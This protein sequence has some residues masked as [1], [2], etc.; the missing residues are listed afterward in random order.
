MCTQGCFASSAPAASQRY[1]R[2]R[3]EP[4]VILKRDRE[5]PSQ[6]EKHAGA[7]PRAGLP[8]LAF[9]SALLALLPCIAGAQASPMQPAAIS[10]TVIVPAGTKVLLTLRSGIDTR[11]AQPGDGVYLTSAFPVVV[12]TH[13][14]IPAGVYVQGVVDRV[15]RAGRVHGRAEVSMHFTTMIFPNGSVV[16]IPGTIDSLPGATGAHVKNAEGDV[17]QAGSKGNDAGT[18]A[19]GAE[20][21]ATIGT[22]G[23][24]IGGSPLAGAGYGAL[25]G[26]VGGLIY[27]L[28]TRGSDVNL[29][30]GQ[31]V[32]MVLQRPLTLT[33]VNLGAA[34]T[35]GEIIPSAQRPMAKPKHENLLCPP[36]GL[37][38]P[39]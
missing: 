9:A 36:G 21:G 11:S 31:T 32:Q 39:E 4:V 2:K 38:C 5:R 30:Q 12:G 28:F 20:T 8:V 25:A 27:T 35:A 23:G 18:I 14:A 26:G 3:Q 37:G 10:P 33:S 13:V 17:E 1:R 16:E 24:A 29:E 15:K 7:S 6:M 22:I 19:R 34:D